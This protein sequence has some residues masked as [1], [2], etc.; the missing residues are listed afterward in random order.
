MLALYYKAFCTATTSVLYG[1]YKRLVVGLQ[2][3]C[4][5]RTKRFVVLLYN[6]NAS[7]VVGYFTPFVQARQQMSWVERCWL[8]RLRFE[9]MGQSPRL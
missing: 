8:V 1:R 7:L 3:A 9:T 4:S 2:A 6:V 5:A